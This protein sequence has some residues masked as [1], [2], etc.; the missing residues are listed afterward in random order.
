M[1]SHGSQAPDSPE[2]PKKIKHHRPP[3]STRATFALG[4]DA[5]GQADRL[6]RILSTFKP[7]GVSRSAVL[8]GLLQLAEDAALGSGDAVVA[9]VVAHDRPPESGKSPEPG[10]P[11]REQEKLWRTIKKAILKN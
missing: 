3:T 8:R 2:I 5:I 7:G 6:A 1:N 10:T 9:A 11:G 4:E